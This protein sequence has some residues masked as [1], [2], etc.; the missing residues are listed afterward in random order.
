MILAVVPAAGHS[1]RMGRPKLSL[2]LAGRTVL[3]WVITSLRRGGVEHVLVVVGPQV[4][5]L[6]AFAQSAGALVLTLEQ[7]TPDMR[8]TV[9]HGLDWL[10]ANYRPRDED[11]WL[12]VPADHPTLDAGVIHELLQ[13]RL[14][15]PESGIVIPTH[16][17]KRGHPALIAWRHVSGI[18][19]LPAGQGLNA[20][21]R[22]H[23][24]ETVELPVA[25]SQVLCDLDTPEDYDRLCN[26]AKNLS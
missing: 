2:P 22:Q 3:E 20:Y 12:L 15:Q 17:G 11:S 5:E 14:R 16:N 24:A 23:T 19:M 8:A 7:G 10:E 1:V 18:R 6:V 9:Q 21:L 4:R 25:S 26:L 13:A